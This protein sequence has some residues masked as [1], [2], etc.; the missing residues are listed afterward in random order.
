[1]GQ[2]VV[3]DFEAGQWTVVPVKLAAGQLGL[4][5]LNGVD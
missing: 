4:Q 5:E 2:I 1:L 3:I